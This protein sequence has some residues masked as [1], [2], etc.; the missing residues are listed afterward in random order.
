MRK[1][2][3]ENDYQYICDD[4]LIM[5]EPSF[6]ILEQNDLFEHIEKETI[7][8]WHENY[9]GEEY[10]PSVLPSVGFYNIVN[11]TSGIATAISSSIPQFNLCEVN[12]AMI[13]LLWN[14]NVSFDE[15]Y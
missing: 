4:E 14:S 7:A 6:E 15:I 13:K 3:E 12:E 9:S 1:K 10:Y 5:I 2:E 8:K 11:G